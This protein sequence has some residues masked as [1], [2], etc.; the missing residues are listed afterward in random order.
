MTN[1]V[2]ALPDHIEVWFLS[3]DK[4]AQLEKLLQSETTQIKVAQAIQ[5]QPMGDYCFDPQVGLYKPGDDKKAK[6]TVL[7][8]ELDTTKKYKNPDS[9]TSLDRQMINCEGE[10]AFDIFCGKALADNKKY[11][12]FEIW[13][14]ISGTMKEVD[15]SGHD[16]TCRR[17]SFVRGLANSCP[18]NQKMAIHIFNE[19][20]K[21]SGNMS[22]VCLNYG[23][24]EIDRL[25][26]SIKTTK[27][28]QLLIITDIYEA[29]ERFVDFIEFT[30]KGTIRGLKKPFYAKNMKDQIKS[31]SRFCK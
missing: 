18:F 24:N 26:D 1:I 22:D 3:V 4:T 20:K 29:H 17:E 28:K 6:E 19:S 15:F 12:P 14:D 27:A 31:L 5:C 30:G 11:P 10:Q 25:I 2:F 7:Y 16:Q 8:E 21:E 23:L 9:A 13:I